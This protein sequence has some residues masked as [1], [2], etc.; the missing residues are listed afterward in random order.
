MT[1][2]KKKLNGKEVAVN[3]RIETRSAHF[4]N[5][6]N[7]IMDC[8]D[9]NDSHGYYLVMNNAAIHKPV[10]IRALIKERGYKYIYLLIDQ[11][12]LFPNA[13]HFEVAMLQETNVQLKQNQDTFERFANLIKPPNI[14]IFENKLGKV[15]VVNT[16][17]LSNTSKSQLTLQAIYD[18]GKILKNQSIVY[19]SF[20]I[21]NCLKLYCISFKRLLLADHPDKPNSNFKN[22]SQF[23]SLSLRGRTFFFFSFLFLFVKKCPLQCRSI[24]KSR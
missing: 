18:A 10:V 5:Y 24:G 15:P 1:V 16:E 3:G 9:R 23:N 8:L 14:Q 4:M 12:L 20:T 7:S 17:K 2:E 19:K 21:A 11:L 13:K 22:E 6:L